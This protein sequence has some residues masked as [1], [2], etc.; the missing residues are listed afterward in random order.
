MIIWFHDIIIVYNIISTKYF[1]KLSTI[2]N[3]DGNKNN[4]NKKKMEENVGTSKPKTYANKI[5]RLT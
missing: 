3:N 1:H 2:K 4:K 5:G